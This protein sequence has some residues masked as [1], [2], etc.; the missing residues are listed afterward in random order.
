MTKL[1]RKHGSVMGFWFG[2][3]YTVVLSQWEAIHEA[4]KT[5]GQAFAGRFCP[6]A[7]NTITHGCGIALQ[8]DLDKW[9][10]ARTCLLQ[11][12]TKKV[13]GQTRRSLMQEP[14]NP[15]GESREETRATDNKIIP[16]ILEEVHSTGKD[17]FDLCQNNGGSWSGKVRASIGRESLNV[18]MRQMCSIRYSNKITPVYNDVRACLEN[19]FARISA[20]NP[21]DYIPILGLFGTPKILGEMTYWSDKMYGHI[22]AYLQAH[23][24]SLDVKCPRDFTD[25]MLLKQEE[26][27]LT[28]QDVEVI[29]WDVMAGGIDTT[30]TTLEWLFYIL[31]D[32]PD[33]QK[34]M[35]DELDKVV[36]PDRLPEWEDRDDLPYVNAVICELMRWK[37]F[38]PFGLPHMTLED[39]EVGG[40]AIPAGAQVLVNYHASFMDPDAWKNPEIFRPERFLEEEKHLARGFM[41]GEMKPD[42]ASYKFIPYGAGARMCVGWGV[43]RAVLWLKVATHYH[44]FTIRN[45]TGKKY[46]MD[47]TFGVTVMPEE[48]N[49]EFTPRP[50]AKL[51]RSIEDNL[52]TNIMQNL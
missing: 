9:R 34:K 43:G 18:Y 33:K 15:Q 44:C 46:N 26:F 19:I 6:P 23:K 3:K 45:P 51:L 10:K 38:A 49:V 50:A 4:L 32:H 27:D 39:T 22:R 25:A 5:R 1:S 36:G 40:Y 41:D 14:E 20:G 35:Q 42:K 31:S 48:Q 7:L 28:D 24:D 16:V 30:A 12:M 52:P 37:H 11:G 17:W 2:S 47:E 29:M 13:G 8:N 21:A